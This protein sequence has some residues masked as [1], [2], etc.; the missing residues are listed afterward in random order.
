MSDADYQQVLNDQA[1]YHSFLREA[2]RWECQRDY[3]RAVFFHEKAFF[4][5]KGSSLEPVSRGELA[6]LYE[7]DGQYEKALEEID[8]F[9]VKSNKSSPLWDRFVDSRQR[10]LQKIE[11]QM[12]GEKI[13]EPNSANVVSQQK[14]LIRRIS[15]FHTA[16]YDDQKQFLEKELPEGTDIL[17]LSKRA[18]LAEHAGNFKDAKGFYEQ[19]LAQKEG[20]AAVYGEAAWVMLHPAVQRMSELT[21]DETREKEMLVWI[22]D[23]M[24]A[25]DGQHHKYLNGLMPP[26]QG[27]LKERLKKFGLNS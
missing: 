20:V 16:G 13:E 9:L 10:L 15:D 17:R 1:D 27:H 18:M 2:D 22:R 8:W 21:G 5:A 24:L 23:Y 26:V 4:M 12:R 25:P 11:A 7:L 19:L 14:Q 6:R 3:G